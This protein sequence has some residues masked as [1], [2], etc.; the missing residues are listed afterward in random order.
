MGLVLNYYPDWSI[1]TFFFPFRTAIANE[2]GNWTWRGQERKTNLFLVGLSFYFLFTIGEGW[3]GDGFTRMRKKLS[4]F[5]Y[6]VLRKRNSAWFLFIFFLY[7]LFPIFSLRCEVQDRDKLMRTSRPC[8]SLNRV[9]V[10]LFES[11]MFCIES[12]FVTLI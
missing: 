1:W 3:T 10:F 6:F 11:C 5:S 7:L 12:S 4:F 8:E 9:W 2:Y